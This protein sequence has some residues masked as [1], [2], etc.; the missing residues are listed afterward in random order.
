MRMQSHEEEMTRV[1]SEIDLMRSTTAEARAT[2]EN[3]LG[4]K[5]VG[6]A[7]AQKVRTYT[8]T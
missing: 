8:H 2:L 1:K 6:H 5:E 7:A 4:N 3:E